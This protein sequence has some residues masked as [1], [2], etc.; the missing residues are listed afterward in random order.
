MQW[1]WDDKGQRYLDLFG[2]IVTVSV[3]HCHPKVKRSI[4]FHGKKNFLCYF[5]HYTYCLVVKY[6]SI[7]TQMLDSIRNFLYHFMYLATYLLYSYFN[8]HY[9]SHIC[10]FRLTKLWKLKSILYGI[11]QV[12]ICIQKSTNMQKN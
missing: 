9:S 5:L 6:K 4:Y 10:I 12:F 3:G 2:G 1:L 8:D 11:Q 7:L